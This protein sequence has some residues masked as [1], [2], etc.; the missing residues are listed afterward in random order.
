MLRDQDDPGMSPFFHALAKTLFALNAIP[1]RPPCHGLAGWVDNMVSE[2]SIVSQV[3]GDKWPFD[4]VSL[5][6]S[7]SLCLSDVDPRK[8]CCHIPLSMI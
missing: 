1:H 7:S 3:S 2:M 4:M 6:P 8:M 5:P